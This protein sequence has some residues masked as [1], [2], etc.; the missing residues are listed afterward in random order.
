MLNTNQSKLTLT[1]TK[2]D[3]QRIEAQLRGIN[4][5][6]IIIVY[7]YCTKLILMLIEEKYYFSTI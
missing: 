1:F 5:N 6:A 7:K 3:R 4:Y 2:E